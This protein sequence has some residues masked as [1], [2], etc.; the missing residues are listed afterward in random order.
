MPAITAK[1][2]LVVSIAGNVLATALIVSLNGGNAFDRLR[3]EPI[4]TAGLSRAPVLPYRAEARQS[5]TKVP[6]GLAGERLERWRQGI[7]DRLQALLDLPAVAPSRPVWTAQKSDS[8]GYTLARTTLPSPTGL[9]RIV[10]YRLLPTQRRAGGAK[11]AVV[12]AIPGSGVHAT[13]GLL[14]RVD[15]YQ[16]AAAPRLA[17]RGYAVYVAESFGAGARG[18]DTGWLGDRGYTSQHVAGMYGLYSGEYLA[19]IFLA[20]IAAEIAVIRT[21]PQVDGDRLATFGISRGGALAML[22]AAREPTVDGAIAASGLRDEDL[23]SASY[24]DHA[25]IPSMGRYF[26]HSDVAGTIAPRPLLITYS[27]RFDRDGPVFAE[28]LEL[29]EEVRTLRTAKRV[30]AIYRMFGARA[31]LRVVVHPRGHTWDETSTQTFLRALFGY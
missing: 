7:L 18:F 22:A 8:S 3:G 14:G 31:M 4:V 24:F 26:L 5:M 28:A 17:E 16:R 30:R 23:Y 15:N 1:R 21:D 2:A 25:V 12:L 11:P 10:M 13:D 27:S 19:R 29:Q 6:G 9:D 20:D